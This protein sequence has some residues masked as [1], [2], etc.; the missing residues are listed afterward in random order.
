MTLTESARLSGDGM[1]VSIGGKFSTWT[2]GCVI[3]PRLSVRLDPFAPI[4]TATRSLP[5]AF[6]RMEGGTR[7]VQLGPV[8][9]PS[10]C[11]TDAMRPSV[12]VT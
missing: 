12:Q 9:V 2:G 6:F 3:V 4:E 1:T 10:M 5:V 7:C 8:V 11:T